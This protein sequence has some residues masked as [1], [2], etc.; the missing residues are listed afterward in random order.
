M[1]SITVNAR[2]RKPF[3]DLSGIVREVGKEFAIV[4]WSFSGLAREKL[5]DLIPI[6][7]KPLGM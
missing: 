2:V 7:P 1:N 4:D 5:A 6:K 3:R